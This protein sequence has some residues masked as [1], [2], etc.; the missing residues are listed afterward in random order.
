MS[1]KFLI[2]I[3][4]Q[5][6]LR[7]RILTIFCVDIMSILCVYIKYMYDLLLTILIRLLKIYMHYDVSL[8]TGLQMQVTF[9]M[10]VLRLRRILCMYELC[11]MML[12]KVYIE[13]FKTLVSFIDNYLENVTKAVQF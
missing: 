10:P 6:F 1:Q 5:Y 12:H 8:S 11:T 2:F 4:I 13:F 3:N 7:V 9:S